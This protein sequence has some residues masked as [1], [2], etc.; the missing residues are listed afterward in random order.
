VDSWR[1]PLRE[2]W[3]FICAVKWRTS[4]ETRG[5]PPRLRPRALYLQIA[6]QPWRRQRKPVSAWTISRLSRH[7]DK[8]IKKQAQSDGSRADGFGC[9]PATVSFQKHIPLIKIV[10]DFPADAPANWRRYEA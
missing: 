9:G 5:R 2:F 1:T 3:R 8:R 4:L 7:R 10:D 6:A